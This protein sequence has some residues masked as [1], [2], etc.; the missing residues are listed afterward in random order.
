MTYDPMMCRACGLERATRETP[1]GRSICDACW[2]KG[3]QIKSGIRDRYRIASIDHFPDKAKDVLSSMVEMS[4]YIW[5][6][7]GVGKTYALCATA[8]LRIQKLERAVRLLTWGDLVRAWRSCF[9]SKG[10]TE[11]EFFEEL[12]KE[13]ALYVDD[14]GD[15][16]GEDSK[17]VKVLFCDLIDR[18]YSEGTLTVVTSNLSLAEISDA[19]SPKAADR[20]RESYAV[21]CFSG[22]NRRTEG[23]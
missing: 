17:G 9:K 1:D 15:L 14:V 4:G 22:V 2:L 16:L 20:I 3:K 7:Y 8:S 19:F 6:K 18:R 21:V 11:E 23:D 12:A 13:K 10:K 5:G